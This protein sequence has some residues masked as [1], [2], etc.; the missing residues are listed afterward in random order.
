MLTSTQIQ[1]FLWGLLIVLTVVYAIYQVNRP[2][3]KGRDELGKLSRDVIVE[4][5]ALFR[6]FSVH[7]TKLRLIGTIRDVVG[8]HPNGDKVFL[9]LG[10]RYFPKPQHR[11][12]PRDP[13]LGIVYKIES[14]NPPPNFILASIERSYQTPDRIKKYSFGSALK[15][16]IEV[17]PEKYEEISLPYTLPFILINPEADKQKPDQLMACIDAFQKLP[18]T[19]NAWV[20]VKD[21]YLL[22]AP[23]LREF[24][25]K[26]LINHRTLNHLWAGKEGKS[27]LD[28]FL[29][30]G[31]EVLSIV[32]NACAL[33]NKK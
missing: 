27:L 4:K 12:P 16:K 13:S 19:L 18:R 32:E 25:K 31:Y 17:L 28:K 7:Q 29:D 2:R 8:N 15:E 20:E 1:L 21:G 9:V 3:G 33:E 26:R 22:Y 11:K 6:S 10:Y 5:G 30:E 14:P 24:N 23:F